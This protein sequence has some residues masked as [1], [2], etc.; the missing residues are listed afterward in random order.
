MLDVIN[1]EKTT[2]VSYFC[3]RWRWHQS[4]HRPRRQASQRPAST[5]ESR[6]SETRRKEIPSNVIN[7]AH[8][9]QTE[10]N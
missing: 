9:A 3:R 2:D 5:A 1:E 7:G 6:G 10:A 4:G 8:W